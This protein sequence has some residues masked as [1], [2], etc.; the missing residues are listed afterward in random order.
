MTMPPGPAE[1]DLK[2]MPLLA[3]ACVTFLAF[4]SYEN[5]VTGPLRSLRK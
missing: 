2:S 4:V 5:S 1:A 3:T